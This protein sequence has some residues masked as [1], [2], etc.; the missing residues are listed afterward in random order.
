MDTGKITISKDGKESSI[1]CDTVVIAVGYKADRSLERALRD[2]IP[3]VVTIGDN[4]APGKVID[5]VHQGYHK[6]RLLEHLPPC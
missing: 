3:T 5:A 1:P 6:V 4:V 2:K